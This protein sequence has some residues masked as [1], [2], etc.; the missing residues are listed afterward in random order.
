MGGLSERTYKFIEEGY[1]IAFHTK[2]L[3]DS[4]IKV[5]K[6]APLEFILCASPE[7]L[8]KH[9]TPATPHDL[10]AHDMLVHVINP[11]W[12][13][14]GGGKKTLF[15]PRRIVFSSNNYLALQKA[16]IRSMG[17]AELPVRSAHHHL[18]CGALVRVLPDYEVPQRPLYAAYAPGRQLVKKVRVFLDFIGEWFKAHPTIPAID[19]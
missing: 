11:V 19:S 17:I 16:S 3:R 10:G 13:F 4:S 7:Y 6:I 12:H 8:A 18:D 1:D 14:T 9:G 2:Q 15:K 5:K